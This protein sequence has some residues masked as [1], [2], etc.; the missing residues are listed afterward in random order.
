MFRVKHLVNLFLIELT[1]KTYY[2]V[3]FFVELFLFYLRSF[4]EFDSPTK[5]NQDTVVDVIKQHSHLFTYPQKRIR[6][7]DNIFCNTLIVHNIT[8]STHVPVPRRRRIALIDSPGVGI[9]L[10]GQ[11]PLFDLVSVVKSV[12][13]RVALGG[14]RRV[15]IDL[16]VIV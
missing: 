13:V 9:F 12:T 2:I 10:V 7:D 16:K 14:A 11:R 5:Q 1:K 15:V 4:V 8:I 3:C 6:V